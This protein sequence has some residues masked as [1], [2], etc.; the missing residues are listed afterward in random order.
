M[1]NVQTNRRLC[2]KYMNQM[3]QIQTNQGTYR[4][5]IVKV[6]SNKVYLQTAKQP[7]HPG[8]ATISFFPLLLP[9]VLFDLLAIVLIERPRPLCPPGP[10]FP[11]G[12][13]PRLF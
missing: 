9:L 1:A 3:V 2:Q 11:G 12:C 8:K 10:F 4:G 7:H 13:G 5:K 6:T